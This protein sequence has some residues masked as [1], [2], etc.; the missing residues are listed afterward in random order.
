M[1][2]AAAIFEQTYIS[3]KRACRNVQPPTSDCAKKQG[4]EKKPDIHLV[5][6]VSQQ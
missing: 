2:Q 6:R 4:K 3:A 5:S 1:N